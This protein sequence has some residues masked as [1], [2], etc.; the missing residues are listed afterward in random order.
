MIALAALSVMV[1]TPGPSVGSPPDPPQNLRVLEIGEDG[2]LLAW[3]E[4]NDPRIVSYRV[5]LS[6]STGHYLAMGDWNGYDAAFSFTTDDGRS[7]NLAWGRTCHNLGVSSTIYCVPAFFDQPEF[8]T[9]EEL[10]FLDSLGMEIGCHSANHVPL[11]TDR[12]FRIRYTGT[13]PS[14]SLWIQNGYLETYLEPDSLDLF[15][16]LQA[17]DYDQYFELCS[18]INSLP[19]YDCIRDFPVCTDSWC[20]TSYTEWVNGVRIDDEWYQAY[21]T[22]GIDSLELVEETAGAKLEIESVIGRP[23]YRCRSFAYPYHAYDEREMAACARAGFLGTRN[24]PNVRRGPDDLANVNLYEKE[25]ISCGSPNSMSETETRAW[26]R[27]LIDEWKQEELWAVLRAFHD[28]AD[29]DSAHLAWTLDEM[30]LDGGIWVASFGDVA[31]YVR[32]YHINVGKPIRNETYVGGLEIGRLY[33]AVVT[34]FSGGREESSWSNEVVFAVGSSTDL[35]N[36]RLPGQSPP[37]SPLLFLHAV[38]NPTSDHPAI[39]LRVARPYVVNVWVYNAAGRVVSSS[40]TPTLSAGDHI[41]ELPVVRGGS[42]SLPAGR[43]FVRLQA[44]E[45]VTTGSF[46]IVR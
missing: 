40:T 23:D 45:S 32:D 39:K 25:V 8:L 2:A 18:E 6:D 44:E 29:I 13:A 3:D 20:R 22:Q 15:I 33:Y 31:E 36:G 41:I 17:P 26:I 42:H 4:S 28:F 1:S 38:P 12:A 37:T 43:Y 24:G 7:A 30:L 5:R 11:V 46:V 16:D 10:R 14:C 35:P 27:D 34:V 21:S 19:D 9:S